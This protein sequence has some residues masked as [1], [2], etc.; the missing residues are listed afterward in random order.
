MK[1][2]SIYGAFNARWLSPEDVARSFIPTLPFKSLVRHQNSLLMGPRGCGKTTLLKMLTRPAQRVWLKERAPNE[3]AWSDYRSPDFEA[4]Y[5]P[6]DVRW[7]AELR[8][9]EKELE[10]FPIAAERVQRASI[11][12]CSLIEASKAFQGIIEESNESAEDVCKALIRHLELGSTIPSFREIRLRLLQWMELIQSGLIKRDA[13]TVRHILDSIPASLTAHSISA[14][15]K[16]CKVFDEYVSSK[17]QSRWA[18]CFDELEIAPEWLQRELLA[19]L[20]SFDQQFLFKLTWSPI[21]PRHLMPQQEK[22]HDYAPIKMWHTGATDARSFCSEFATRFLRDRLG[23][24][25]LNPRDVFGPSPFA[26]EDSDAVG[27]YRP[28]SPEWHA[29]V[30]LASIDTSFREYL[31]KRNISP[32]NPATDSVA[33]R[34][35]SLRKVKPIVLARE[36]HLKEAGSTIKRRSRKVPPLYYGDDAVYAMSEGNPRLLAGL[37]NE[38]LDI[39][40]RRSAKNA[41]MI[42][43]LSQSRVLYA[44]SLRMLTTVRSY[45]FKGGPRKFPLSLLVSRLGNFQRGELIGSEFKPD[46]VGSFFVDA[47][48]RPEIMEEI[49]KGLLIGA[50]V[51]MGTQE[52]DFAPSVMGSR[53]RLSYVLSPAFQLLFR[54]FREMRLSTALRMAPW[55]QT[56]LFKAAE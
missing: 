52:D 18:L 27:A 3:P 2:A 43:R 37:L 45:P 56:S 47:D 50:F 12:I 10:G 26:Q 44:A 48:V 53:I 40:R 1:T 42:P 55:H 11:A 15:T 36:A 31:E 23:D 19:S 28:G 35:E 20:R 13:D 17:S 24:H 49:A 41:P 6:S 16:A 39:E 21:L 38:L 29:M 7:G 33:L 54:N 34:D 25:T 9:V 14:V 32:S 8:S 4:I 5:I 51:N 22:L 46:P 30:Q